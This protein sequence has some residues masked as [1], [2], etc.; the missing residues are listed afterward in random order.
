MSDSVIYDNIFEAIRFLNPSC[1]ALEALDGKDGGLLH[2]QNYQLLQLEDGKYGYFLCGFNSTFYRGEDR[3]YDTCVPSL[4]RRKGVERIIA[5]LRAIDFILY[6]KERPDIQMEVQT[7][8]H[9]DF[10]A[11][12]QHYGF[13]TNMVDI[14]EDLMTAAYFATHAYDEFY[15]DYAVVPEGIGQIRFTVEFAEPVGRLRMIG[16]QPLARPGLQSGYGIVLD[17]NEDF[18]RMSGT[19]KFK[20]DI[21]MNQR[22]HQLFLQGKELYF[23]NEPEMN[24]VTNIIKESNAVTSKA[25]EVYCEETGENNAE[26]RKQLADAKIFVVDA[27]L[28]CNG[29]PYYVAAS[30]PGKRKPRSFRP[31]MTIG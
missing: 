7:G 23:P 19:V 8:R 14:T 11:L 13:A 3:L 28:V 30:N 25:V 15:K 16:L 9:I 10:L 18:A 2:S 17:E 6:L 12:A 20:Q 21:D 27:P 31:I 29:M 4:Y 24:F 26:V 5:R 1:P 22:F